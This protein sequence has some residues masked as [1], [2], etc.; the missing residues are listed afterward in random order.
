M[1]K[2]KSVILKRILLLTSFMTAFI[3]VDLVVIFIMFSN[4]DG[5]ANAIDLSGAERMRTMLLGSYGTTYFQIMTDNVA[6]KEEQVKPVRS[7]IEKEIVTYEKIMDGLVNGNMELGLP[8]TTDRKILALVEEWKKDWYPFKEALITIQK[9]GISAWDMAQEL[10]KIKVFKAIELKDKVNAVVNAY[11]ALSNARLSLIKTLLIIIIGAVLCIAAVIIL[12]MRRDLLPIRKLVS[13]LEALS[14]RD[15]TVRSNLRAKNEIGSLGETLDDMSATLDEFIGKIKAASKDVESSNHS[16]VSAVEESGA[17]IREMVASIDSINSSIAKSKSVIRENVI[18]VQ[19]TMKLTE[20][21]RKNVDGQASAVA[22]S[23]ASVEQMVGSIGSVGKNTERARQ[24]S[25]KLSHTAKTGNE[26]ISATI[27]AIQ[28]IYKASEKISESLVGISKIAA[29]TNLLSMNAAIEAA[30]AGDAGRG[31]AVVA[32]EIRNL[33]ESSSLEAKNIRQII[34]ETLERIKHGTKLSE[35]A[36]KAFTEIMEDINLT[37][38][39]NIEIA[40]A[41]NE[42]KAGTDEILKSMEHLV[43]LSTDIGDAVQKN[44]ENSKGLMDSTLKLERVSDEIV[45]A[46]NEQKLGGDE[47]LQA[48]QMLQDVAITNKEIVDELNAKIAEFKV[49]GT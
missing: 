39:T 6:D 31:F 15:L 8:K 13:V 23:S 45:N 36:G 17:A 14:R 30:H 46:S 2:V 42:Q 28:E 10:Q 29:M 37:V 34:Q 40:N 47:I 7:G 44:T 21:I 3:A 18:S 20:D 19:E 48:L 1:K 26:K 43:R 4:M 49:S 33:A 5:L 24:I 41:M 11:T 35:E 12:F 38:D 16:L 32:Q 22:Q 25:E 9:P 27:K